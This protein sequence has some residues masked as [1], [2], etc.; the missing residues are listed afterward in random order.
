L[1]HITLTENNKEFPGLHASY[2]NMLDIEVTIPGVQNL[3]S[4]TD[5]NKSTGL[6]ELS[7]RISKEVSNEIAFILMFIFNQS[8]WQGVLP[9]N[10]L[11]DYIKRAK[12]PPREL[13]T[14]ISICSKIIEHIVHSKI[15]ADFLESNSIL[16]SWQHGF[17]STCTWRLG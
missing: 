17:R 7:S 8:L 16:S 11:V 5:V 15:Y 4:K 3:L 10:W 13:Q 9:H 2:P 1:N 14:N 6:D 12:R